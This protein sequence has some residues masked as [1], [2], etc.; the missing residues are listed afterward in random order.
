MTEWPQLESQSDD[1]PDFM[2][3]GQTD[4]SLDS[5]Q[6]SRYLENTS[7]QESDVFCRGYLDNYLDS[8]P[9]QL[10]LT[11]A[12]L[13]QIFALYRTGAGQLVLEKVPSEGS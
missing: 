8:V 1:F 11:P 3:W 6:I 4:T 2:R 9:D 10:A 13:V 5:M 12:M 7:L